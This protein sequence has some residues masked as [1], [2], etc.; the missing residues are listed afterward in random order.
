MAG[1]LSMACGAGSGTIWPINGKRCSSSN[2]DERGCSASV[3]TGTKFAC[4]GSGP[5]N[6]YQ[7]LDGQ[8]NPTTHTAVVACTVPRTR[9]IRPTH[10]AGLCARPA[11]TCMTLYTWRGAVG[12]CAAWATVRLTMMTRQ[13]ST[14]SAMVTR[15]ISYPLPIASDS[16]RGP[17]HRTL[18]LAH[19]RYCWR[20]H[21][22]G[23]SAR[24][25][26]IRWPTSI[27]AY[28]LKRVVGRISGGPLEFASSII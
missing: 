5:C 9:T 15:F 19:I 17:R 20:I 10:A 6:S 26:A 2:R 12:D 24:T 14:A 21:G 8:R 3:N 11:C 25:S 18:A 4:A 27:V 23:Q 16:D 28:S 7:L 13:I 1:P 22:N